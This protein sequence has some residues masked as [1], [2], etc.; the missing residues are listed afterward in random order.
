M[1]T[2]PVFF[3]ALAALA[4]IIYVL[5][6]GFDLGVGIIFMAAPREADRDAMM[7]SLE[8]VWDGN[9]TWLVMGGT[10]LF[11]AFPVAYA[12]L[13]PALY[14]PIIGMLLALVVRGVAFS[15]R[16][17]ATRSRGVWSWA[18]SLASLTAA[19][20]QGLVLGGIVQGVSVRDGAFAGG[21]FDF[22][23]ILGVLCGVGLVAGYALLG[24]SWT[25]W[26]SNGPTQTFAREIAHAALLLAMAMMAIVSAWTAWHEP[27]IAARWFSW[28]NIA[29][30][31]PVPAVTALAAWTLW[32]SLWGARDIRPFLLSITLF[33]LGFGGLAVSL[34]P[35]IVP[36]SVT[37][38]QG[39]ADP[40]SL[41]FIAPGL[42]VV[43]PIVLGYQFHAYRVFRGKH[44]AHSTPPA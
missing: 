25:I 3:A 18:F 32:R 29:L 19:F 11:A 7:G 13:L 42:I 37:I 6:D 14:V 28:P 39:A 44:E 41:A 31:A 15:F 5:A 12:V 20:C 30:L 38:W 10:L 43:M 24:A 26:R 34:W 21:V 23:S 9:E 4:V 22:V 17:N 35:Y 33:L 8:P 1:A 2:D 40:A 27:A 36:R 16:E